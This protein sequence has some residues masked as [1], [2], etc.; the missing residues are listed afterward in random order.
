MLDSVEVSGSEGGQREGLMCGV[1]L[2]P[3]LQPERL[4]Y[5]LKKINHSATSYIGMGN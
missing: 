5:N 3:S 4:L 1:H 2:P